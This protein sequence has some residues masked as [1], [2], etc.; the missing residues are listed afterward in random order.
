MGARPT[1]RIRAFPQNS[2]A[3]LETPEDPRR[4]HARL[5][6]VRLAAFSRSPN[7]G[8]FLIHLSTASGVGI[9]GSRQTR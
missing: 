6:P 9:P 4:Q 1:R 2:P 5:P 7:F 3:S 8:F